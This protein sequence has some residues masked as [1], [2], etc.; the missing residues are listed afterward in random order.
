MEKGIDEVTESCPPSAARVILT[1]S[2]SCPV[3]PPTLMESMRNFSKAAAS[4]TEQMVEKERVSW[5]L[6]R[7]G[8]KRE[9]E[10][11]TLVVGG[12]REVDDEGLGGSSLSNDLSSRYFLSELD[13]DSVEGTAR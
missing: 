13:L 3:F 8:G 6:Q 4:K 9:E 5:G 7:G 2:P 11:R 12:S 10:K 1:S